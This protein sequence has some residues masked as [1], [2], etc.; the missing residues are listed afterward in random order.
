MRSDKP[1]GCWHACFV[2]NHFTGE[3]ELLISFY[4]HGLTH[5]GDAPGMRVV[6][7]ERYKEHK[8]P[9]NTV[10]AVFCLRK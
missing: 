4:Q 2:K 7:D 3:Q 9:V 8:I 5:F 1:G 10:E 6:C